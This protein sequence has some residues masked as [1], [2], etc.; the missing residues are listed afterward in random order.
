MM[1]S[2]CTAR[3]PVSSRIPSVRFDPDSLNQN[4][5]D[6]SCPLRLRGRDGDT[7]P[8]QFEA[9]VPL[10]PLAIAALADAV[11]FG[12]PQFAFD[13]SAQL[14]QTMYRDLRADTP[15]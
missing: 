13:F 6:V 10:R 12:H 3:L 2:A 7:M 1:F 14:V 11:V 5:D 9:Q 15:N 8:I 4:F